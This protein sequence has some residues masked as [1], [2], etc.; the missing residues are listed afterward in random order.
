MKLM[1]NITRIAPNKANHVDAKTA[2][3]LWFC[4][5]CLRRYTAIVGLRA[6]LPMLT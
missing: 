4:H 5:R 2:S 6:Q 3:S 1:K